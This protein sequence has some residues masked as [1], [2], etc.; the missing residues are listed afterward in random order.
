VVEVPIQRR[1]VLGGIAAA[2]ALCV[3]GDAP[4]VAAGTPDLFAFRACGI[5]NLVFAIVA[6]AGV[7][8]PNDATVTFHVGRRAWVVNASAPPGS[9]IFTEDLGRRTAAIV[10]TLLSGIP[11]LRPAGSL[12][13]LTDTFPYFPQPACKAHLAVS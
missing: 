4:M 12:A 3:S 11:V 5:D 1:V 7:L 9:G 8:P 6:Q 13:P 2:V 10:E